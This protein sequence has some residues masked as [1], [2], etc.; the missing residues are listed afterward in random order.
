[1][2]VKTSFSEADLSLYPCVI[3]AAPAGVAPEGHLPKG[4][5]KR[6]TRSGAIVFTAICLLEVFRKPEFNPCQNTC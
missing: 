1:M 2:A 6:S 3:R 5:S 4:K